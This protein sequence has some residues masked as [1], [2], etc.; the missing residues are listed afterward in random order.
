MI[1]KYFKA[2]KIKVNVHTVF[3]EIIFETT[4]CFL[5]DCKKKLKLSDVNAIK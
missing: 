5:L 1:N 3:K 4:F 2:V